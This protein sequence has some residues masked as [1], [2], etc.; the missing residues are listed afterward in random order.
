MDFEKYFPYAKAR[1]QQLKVIEQLMENWD[2]KK[3]FIL[4]LD[5]GTGKSGIAKCMAN[6]C[7]SSFIITS[8]KQLQDQYK[9]DFANEP[10]MAEIKGKNNYKCLRNSRTTCD[11]ATCNIG[12]RPCPLRD[13]C[14][15]TVQRKRAQASQICLTS[16]AY[17][18]KAISNE[19]MWPKRDLIVFDEAHLLESELVNMTSFYLKSNELEDNFDLYSSLSDENYRKV[20]SKTTDDFWPLIELTSKC[21]EEKIEDLDSILEDIKETEID[22]YKKTMRDKEKLSNLN[23]KICCF[24]ST[25]ESRLDWLVGRTA[26]GGWQFTP[27]KVKNLFKYFCSEWANKFIFM[28]ATIL[29]IDG[30]IKQLGVD[31]EDCCVIK[32]ESEFDPKKS[33]IY[34]MPCG[35]MSYANMSTTLPKEGQIVQQIMKSHNDEKGIIHTGNYKVAHYLYDNYKSPRYIFN[36]D[37][38][39]NNQTLIERHTKSFEPTVLL[40]PS[41][42]TGV[43]LRD[44]LSRWQIVCK[45]PYKSLADERVKKMSEIDP[46]WYACDTLRN[47]IQACGRS[48]RSE[49][50]SSKTYV[51]DGGFAR[52]VK[53]HKNWLPQSFLKRIVGLDV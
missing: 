31:P 29:D 16:Y 14:L 30:Y 49:D 6:Y 20:M 44:D 8:T 11:L 27:L 2:K 34:F 46:D 18:L 26:E 51:L 38:E 12:G 7:P 19:G 50:D 37:G 47:L 24:K 5:V 15:Y 32:E 25:Y 17:A 42:T 1:P 41:M 43:D 10:N 28:S 39:T 13:K 52:L 9:Y 3:Y 36:K 4:Q 35:S 45:L 40:S 48:T 21:I 33:P 23:S 53:M 22:K